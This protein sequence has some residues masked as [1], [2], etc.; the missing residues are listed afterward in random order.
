MNKLTFKDQVYEFPSNMDELTLGDWEDIEAM[1]KNHI[2]NGKSYDSVINIISRITGVFPEDIWA[3]PKEL[4]F[5][6]HNACKFYFDFKPA[7]KPESFFDIDGVRYVYSEDP[8]CSFME[9]VDRDGILQEYPDEKKFSGMLAIYLRPEGEAY[10]YKNID[11]R[12]KLFKKQPASKFIPL[13]AFFLTKEE[14]LLTNLKAYSMGLQLAVYQGR[15]LNS[16]ANGVGTTSLWNWRKKTL[17]RLIPFYN[18]QL[19]KYLTSYLTVETNLKQK[20]LLLDK[21]I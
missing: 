12:I 3:A 9:W 11:K 16:A 5:D 10:N 4:C 14:L 1:K 6:L 7:A 2:D 15:M 18:I 8:N 21:T 20:G 13:I 19:E 17:Q